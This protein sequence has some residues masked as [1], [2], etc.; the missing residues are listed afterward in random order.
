M[1]D[2]EFSAP[3]EVK[4]SIYL[5]CG[6][7]GI[8]FLGGVVEYWQMPVKVTSVGDTTLIVMN[9]FIGVFALAANIVFLRMRMNWSRFLLAV[10]FV[11]GLPSNLMDMFK[12]FP[13]IL[14]VLI[15]IQIGLE[16]YAVFL[17]FQPPSSEWFLGD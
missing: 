3:K 10:M 17:I 2:L 15:L 11:L 16:A 9:L 6:V 7:L 8:V 13:S 5:L 12:N 1:A 4:K 14:G